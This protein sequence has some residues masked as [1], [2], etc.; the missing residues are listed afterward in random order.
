MKYVFD[1]YIWNWIFFF[2]LIFLFSPAIY[3]LQKVLSFQFSPPALVRGIFLLWRGNVARFLRAADALLVFSVESESEREN[4][5]HGQITVWEIICKSKKEN[6]RIF[7]RERG[8]L[9]QG[10]KGNRGE[11]SIP[12]EDLQ[13]QE[14]SQVDKI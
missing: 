2:W 8:K 14:F 4:F 13:A 1:V 5:M 3:I 12:T 10:G 6:Q 11:V 7:M 9:L